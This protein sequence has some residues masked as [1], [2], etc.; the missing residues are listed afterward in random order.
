MSFVEDFERHGDGLVRMV[1]AGVPVAAACGSLGITVGR[2]YEILRAVGRRGSGRRTVI[3]DALREQVIAAFRESGNITGAGAACGLR[4]DTARRILAV[5]GLVP[6]VRAVKRKAQAKV[7]LEEL[8]E[9]GWSITRAAREVGVHPRTARGPQGG[10]HA[11]LSG[12]AGRGPHDRCRDP[13]LHCY[14]PIC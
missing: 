13:I 2:G 10:Q 11:G 6:A 3:T 8:M 12:R 7:R 5:A 1:D 14:A 9:A 4:H